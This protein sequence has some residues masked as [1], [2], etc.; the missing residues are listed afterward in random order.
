MTKKNGNGRTTQGLRDI[1]F[2]EIESVRGENS[3]PSKSMAVAKLAQQILNTAKVEM[4]F[5]RTMVEAANAGTPL[6]LGNLRLGS[7]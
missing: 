4:Q 2:E 5:A 3:D 6:Q 1:L 7:E